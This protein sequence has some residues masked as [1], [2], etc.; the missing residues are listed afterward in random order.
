MPRLSLS[1][2][3]IKPHY[4]VVIV[5]SGYGGGIA[6]SRLSRAGQQVCVLERGKEFQA[7]DFPDTF[8]EGFSEIQIDKP[9]GHKGSRTA[10]YDLRANEDMNVLVGCGLGGGS[11]IN[12]NVSLPAEP[13]VFEDTKWP[14]ALRDDVNTLL[15]DGY[16]RATDMLKP[17]PYP[18]HFPPLLKNQALEKSAQAMNE[19][20]YRPP[21][22]VTFEDGVNHV[23][24]HQQAC[25]LCGDCVS[26]CNH[27]AKNTID[28]NYLPDAHNHGAEI[29][30]QVSVRYL[31][32]E[33]NR[34]VIHYQLL[35]VGREKFDSPTLFVTADMVILSAGS[36]GSTEI[37]LRS[38]AKGL[39]LSDNVGQNFTG[40]GDVWGFGYNN[41]QAI[42]GIGYGNNPPED[43]EAVGPCIT[44]IIDAR[45][46]PT[47][48]DGMVIEDGA[49]PG[50]MSTFL[51][52]A[53]E[54]AAG[55]VGKD[56]DSGLMDF[57]KEKTR[58]LESV[59][60]GAYHGATYNTQTFLVMAH[61][62]GGGRLHL[63]DDRLRISWPGVGEQPVF[64]N[65][66]ARLQEAT[67]ALGGTFVMNPIWS[68]FLGRDA[69]APHPLGGCNMAEN[70]TQ[71]TV[72]HKGQVFSSTT[73]TDVYDGLYV[74][75]GAVIPR[76][77]GVNPL[78]TIS[79]LAER[80]CAIMAKDRGWTIPYDLPSK[81]KTQ[82]QPMP[83]GMHSTER[84]SGFFSTH[85]K[86][87]YQS[88][89]TRGK[90]DDSSMEFILTLA[91]DNV[92]KVLNDPEHTARIVGTITAPALS[93]DPMVVTDG[94][95][96]L[97]S[98]D[99]AQVETRN[100]RYRMK[101]TTEAGK[102][103]YFDGFK[104]IR[105]DPGVD[106]WP[107]TSTLYTTI[108]DGASA[109]SPVLGKGILTIDPI[110]FM[111]QVSTMQVR[112][113]DSLI[114]RLKTR[115]KFGKFFFGD[116]FDIYGGIFSKSTIFDPDAL[117]RKKRPL[118]VEAPHVYP[119]QT[120]DGVTLRLTRY[121][122]GDKGPVMLIHGLGVSSLIFSLDTIDTNL[123]EFL[124]AQGYDVWLLDYRFSI[125]LPASE[126]QASADDV[127][128]YDHPA[129]VAK[130]REITGAKDIQVVA[131]CLGSLTF[132]MSML[133]GLQGVRSAVSSQVATHYEVPTIT[134]LKAGL[135]L[136][137]VL[138]TLG[139]DSLNA[140][141]DT[142]ADWKERLLNTA[143]KVYPIQNEEHCK[144][145]TCHRI[146]FMYGVLYEHDQLNAATHQTLHET[147]GIANMKVFDHLGRL[148][149]TGSMVNFEGEDAYLPHVDRLKIPI[150]FIHGEENETFLPESTR[151]TLAF[152]RE[153]N[154]KSLY[155]RHV[156]P[157][158]GHIDCIFGK[159]SSKDVYPL[160]LNHLEAT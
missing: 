4:S 125:D 120:E 53:L 130:V 149:R 72:N 71:G 129:A 10:L 139:V 128:K 86:D 57:A 60:R 5:G 32:R 90:Q 102:T 13:R 101:M 89:A 24:V 23:G 97:F 47:L 36:L 96:N 106:L 82:A 157:D 94:T 148:T 83:L 98:E 84:M 8:L 104:V 61:D 109:D 6:A 81:P 46:K 117:P 99:P 22:N 111:R 70:A 9:Q 100:M 29:F 7:G 21:I 49:I 30:T 59:V 158:Y 76:S 160:I 44:G 66:N 107:D 131:H 119:F 150:T 52:V 15:K 2:E 156:I 34:W 64:Y 27:R 42:N 38:K 87:D 73:G 92:D 19:P 112:H 88:G 141:V 58:A 1:I 153:K 67:K 127:A 11:L 50:A 142:H 56:M 14:K 110:D 108:Y 152:L 137:E 16:N 133:G 25:K 55:L 33:N 28:M 31:E 136:P 143:L 138:K 91:S 51:P 134:Q 80:A 48:N 151:K 85:V 79:A 12:A 122:G 155:K 63:E 126:L 75:D 41:D 118:R 116:L 74:N 146:S 124:Y 114:D 132:F 93:P 115:V 62:D 144:S 135:H 95:F 140:Y 20:F 37:L 159:N 69:I 145:P 77:V 3:H 54:A 26:G 121:R 147:F 113:A 43:R 17:Q 18:D 45:K 65:I 40:N 154:G 68:R 39:P 78:L 123:L 105:N 103:Y 35:D